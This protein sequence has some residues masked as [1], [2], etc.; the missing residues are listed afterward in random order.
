MKLVL[1][2]DYRLGI[3]NGVDRVV[4]AMGALEGSHFHKPQDLIEGVIT[5]WD[6]LKPAIESAIKGK[7]GVPIDS[8]KLRPPVP[9][10]SK[11][12]CAAI[13]YLEFGQRE[14]ANLDAFIKA[15]TAII[16]SGD[17]CVLPPINAT[18]FHHEPE[19]A[20]VIG[21]TARNVSQDEA[22]SYIFGY[23]N[24]LDMSARGME[25]LGWVSFFLGKCHDTFAPIGPA[26]VTA[27]EVPDPMNIQIRLWN[28]DEPRHDFPTSDMAH[29]I[30][31]LISEYSKVT[32]LE[33]GDVIST[34]VNHQQIGAVQDGDVISMKINELGPPLVI[35]ISDPM[36]RK[37]PRGIDTAMGAKVVAAAPRRS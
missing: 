17:T 27:D 32:T 15:S 18:V 37:W 35:H 2:D 14:P 21:K 19:L 1:Y 9:K 11:I 6:E 29:P 10:P 28:N 13:N 33:P 16:G 25:P 3:I 23:C 20:L 36:K 26:L 5:H 24:F 7:D 22:M 8:V 12:L 31:E 4:D 30:A 34:G